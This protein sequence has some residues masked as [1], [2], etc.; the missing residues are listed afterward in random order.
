MDLVAAGVSAI[1]AEVRASRCLVQCFPNPAASDVIANV[2]LASGAAP[3]F[4]V[5][6][7]EAAE[8]AYKLPYH[9]G[10][11]SVNIGSLSAPA[12]ESM[13]AAAS[14]SKAPWVLDPVGCGGTA[15]RTKAAVGLLALK[16]ALV[17]GNASEVLALH[18]AG[19]SAGPRGVDAADPAEAALPAAVALARKHGCVVVV[20]G[21]TDYV[22][23]GSSTYAV[24][25]GHVGVQSVT[26]TGCA[27]SALLG[28]FISCALRGEG[29]GGARLRY[30]AAGCAFYKA[31]TQAATTASR[32]PGSLK[33]ALMDALADP[34]S[35]EVGELGVSISAAP[36]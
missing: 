23:D 1:V 26:G 17:R 36:C 15:H 25:G 19:G 9:A 29:E 3:A 8:F 5:G 13:R 21:A 12:L 33:V 6:I 20:T 31:A 18:G 2:L 27:L 7:E 30:V 28:A 10:A 32:G 14:A 24:S 11:L 34:A 16:P 4:V 22:T 35:A